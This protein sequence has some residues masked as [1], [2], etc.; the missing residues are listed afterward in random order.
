[1]PYQFN[2]REKQSIQREIDMFLKTGIIEEI[3][4]R[5][6]DGEFI[7]NIFYRPKSN[8]KIRI[9]LNLKPF[10]IDYTNKIHFKMETLATAVANM[11]Q[12]CWLGSVDL[13]DAFYSI[14]VAKKHRHMLR[15]V[16]D[17]RK[18]Q[19]C[20]LVMGLSSSPRVFSKVLKPAYAYLRSKGYVSTAYIDDSCLQG[21]TKLK[22]EQNIIDTITLFDRLGLTINI[23]K[24]VLRPCQQLTFLGFVLCSITMT[25]TLTMTRKEEIRHMCQAMVTKK[26]TT[27]REFAKLIGKLVAATPGVEYATLFIRPLEKIKEHALSKHN[28][29]FNSY[30]NI[31]K[32]IHPSL[33]W[34]IN[35]IESSY[36]KIYHGPPDIIIYSD[37]SK[38]GWG[39]YNKTNGQKTGGIW[40]AGEQSMHINI[41][42]LKACQLT[43]MAFCKNETNKHLKLYMDNTNSVAYLKNFGGRTDD[44]HNLARKLWLWCLEK[45]L[46][47][48]VAHVPGTENHQADEI[49][50]TINDDTEWSL[51]D[52][53]FK[54]IMNIHNNMQVDLFASKLNNKLDLYVSRFPDHKAHQIDAFTFEW[55][56]CVF[57]MFPPFSLIS[58]VLQKVVEDRTEA[59]LVGPIWPT[60]PWWPSLLQLISGSCHLLPLPKSILTLPHKPNKMYPLPKMRLGLFRLSGN[61]S[62][63]KEFQNKLETLSSDRGEKLQRDN[64]TDILRNGLTTVD[65]RRIPLNPI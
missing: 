47:L 58:K 2:E 18:F 49:S 16:F 23:E 40:S 1:M 53:V 6:Y 28:G 25:V 12:N 61:R 52:D 38:T 62:K 46:H 21:E 50:R 7:S 3:E 48:S 56:S 22:C 11:R 5:P 32:S 36:K 20:A 41:L 43:V 4:N 51:N 39:G 9:I 14:E 29:N 35:N 45:K 8:D 34:W 55:K 33:Q 19:F 54:K 37:A 17:G 42:E 57:Y 26:R 24:S 27:I 10:N 13:A 64:M 15:F 31:P 60:Q 30:M 44:L 65:N 59:V 63:T